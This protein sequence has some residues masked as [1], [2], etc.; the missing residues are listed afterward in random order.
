MGPK[1]LTDLRHILVSLAYIA[2][3]A[4]LA[5]KQPDM[6]SVVVMGAIWLGMLFLSGVKREYLLALI[7]IG[8]IVGIMGYDLIL[9]DIQ[10]KRIT[11]FINPQGDPLGSGYNV[12]QSVIAVGSGGLHGQGLGHGSQSQLNFLPEHH[13]D[14]I[15]AAIAEESGLIGATLVLGLL[16]LLLWRLKKTSDKAPDS[17]GRF[18]VGGVMVM[19]FFQSLVNIGMNLGILPIAGLSLPLLS[20][21]GSFIVSTFAALG[22]AQSVWIRQNNQHRPTRDSS[23]ITPLSHR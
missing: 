19:I 16:L 6:G 1:N 10:K 12:I 2:I 11:T 20:Y 18:L 17:F 13:T 7:L 9:N 15:F 23:E 14:F 5:Y 21:G 3:P 8:S 4:F 22:L